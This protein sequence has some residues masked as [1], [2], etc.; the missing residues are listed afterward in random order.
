MNTPALRTLPDPADIDQICCSEIKGESHQ[1]CAIVVNVRH[2]SH[3]ADG[4]QTGPEPHYTLAGELD[5]KKID[6]EDAG[7]PGQNV[8]EEHCRQPAD[9]GNERR[10]QKAVDGS[11]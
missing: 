10:S 9:Q 8:C 7:S 4:Q 2:I 11:Q 5:S 6:D 3:A 1:M